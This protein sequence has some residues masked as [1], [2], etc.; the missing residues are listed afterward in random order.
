MYL[1]MYFKRWRVEINFERRQKEVC[2][3]IN[4]S[5]HPSLCRHRGSLGT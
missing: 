2:G 5:R 4:T 1:F 3:E